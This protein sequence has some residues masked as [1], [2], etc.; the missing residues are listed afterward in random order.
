ME[1]QGAA[2]AVKVSSVSAC[3]FATVLLLLCLAAFQSGCTRTQTQRGIPPTWNDL[4][5]AQLAVGKTEQREVLAL[6]G[7]PSQV[8]THDRGQIFYYLHEEASSR[9]LILLLYNTSSTLTE[10][11]RAIFFFDENGVLRDYSLSGNIAGR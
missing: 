5:D 8:I 10:Y 1:T 4:S 9:G 6:L 2:A 3:R 11:D 7:P